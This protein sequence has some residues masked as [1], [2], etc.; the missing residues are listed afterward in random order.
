MGESKELVLYF[1]TPLNG[2]VIVTL[3]H[4]S[5]ND[6]LGLTSTNCLSCCCEHGNNVNKQEVK[7]LSIAGPIMGQR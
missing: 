3:A 6:R 4:K 1:A 7:T 2:I 5:V